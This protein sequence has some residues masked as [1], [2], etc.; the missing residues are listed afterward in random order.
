[1]IDTRDFTAEQRLFAAVLVTAIND[2]AYDG[3]RKD[4]LNWRAQARRFVNPK[5]PMFSFVCELLNLPSKDACD[6]IKARWESGAGEID[7]D[8]VHD[9]REAEG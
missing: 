9:K 6:A 5:H 4:R 7:V 8:I 1:M 2:G 3:S